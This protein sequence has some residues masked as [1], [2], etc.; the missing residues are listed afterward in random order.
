MADAEQGRDAGGLLI[1]VA[2]EGAPAGGG[3][4]QGAVARKRA[5]IVAAATRLFL[6]HGFV[7]TST[8]QIAADAAVSKQTVYN[9]FGDKEALFREVVLGVAATAEQFADRVAETLDPADDPDAVGRALHALARRYVRTVADPQ[10]LALRRLVIGEVHR[11]P[12]LAAIYHRRS[13]THVLEILAAAFAR[14][15]ARGLLAAD[16]PAQAADH[17]AHLVVGPL[18]DRGMFH[19][20]LAPDPAGDADRAARGVEVFLAAYGVATSS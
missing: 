18:L 12:E 6:D 8:D 11:F 9:Q 1:R 3:G 7:D 13:P 5:T 10:V 16:D 14:L 2:A 19:Q 15:T 4:R 20:H 17:F